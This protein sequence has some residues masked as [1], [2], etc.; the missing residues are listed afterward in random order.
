MESAVNLATG[1][2]R[3]RVHSLRVALLCV[4]AAA[5]VG[6]VAL[7]PHPSVVALSLLMVGML[8]AYL[9]TRKP[10]GGIDWFEVIV[11]F[12]VIYLLAYGT[13]TYF[14]LENPKYLL[15]QSLYDYL[16]P[17]LW[18]AAVGFVA[19][20]GGYQLGFRKLRPSRIGDLR[21]R[22]TLPI[23][24]LGGIGFV[25]QVASVLIDRSVVAGRGVPGILSGL[26]QLAPLF[27]AAWF[28]AWYAALSST[29]PRWQRWIAPALLA[30]QV[31]FALYGTF[32]G[33]A[34]AITLFG[35]PAIAYW[36]VRRRLPKK[37]LVVTAL[38]GVFVVFPLYNTFRI[39]KRE[40]G[41]ERRLSRTVY[42]ITETWSATDY[43]NASL[44][45]VQARLAVVTSPA[46]VLRATPR[47]VDY[48]GGETIALAVV[49]LAVPR[50]FWPDKPTI[51]TGHEF[52]KTFGL[53][54]PVDTE[55]QIAPTLVGE[56]YWNF[57]FAGVVIGCFLIGL[58]LRWI[59]RRYGEG[60]RDDAIR[61]AVYVALLVHSMGFEGNISVLLAGYVKMLVFLHG[62]IWLMQKLG[63]VYA[64]PADR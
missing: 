51:H 49:S 3:E 36:Y 5:L 50:L 44:K 4:M 43:L 6:V 30:P 23:V 56:L 58:L 2:G 39:Q 32:G 1:E 19:V 26:Q 13:G 54:L 52:G 25:G 21:L 40:M 27:L 24:F 11:P 55:T 48:K 45:A 37:F 59:Y 42:L 47:W 28:L 53:L 64:V 20:F 63:W 46:A 14:L 38:I 34:F 9:S 7:L 31:A 61:K 29:A 18:L 17:A 15:Y 62:T 60:G 12:T 33:K 16:V 57:G 10:H 8:I 22:G 41:T 35:L